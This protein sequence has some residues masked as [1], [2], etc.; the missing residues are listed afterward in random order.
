MTDS[1]PDFTLSF[2]E[3]H[4]QGHGSH[5]L[6]THFFS[7]IGIENVIYVLVHGCLWRTRQ[8]VLGEAYIHSGIHFPQIMRTEN[9]WLSLQLLYFW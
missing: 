4:L 1:L 7:F 2:T 9:N 5:T 6:R 3:E 8:Y